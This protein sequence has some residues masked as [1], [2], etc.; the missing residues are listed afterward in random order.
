MKAK[1]CNIGTG[2][3]AS[4]ALD[5]HLGLGSRQNVSHKVTQNVS[6]VILDMTI[7]TPPDLNFVSRKSVKTLKTSF[8]CV[9]FLIVYMQ[10]NCHLFHPYENR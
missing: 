1:K 9:Q 4:H 3:V 7:L 10:N 5:A 8:A 2:R 6:H